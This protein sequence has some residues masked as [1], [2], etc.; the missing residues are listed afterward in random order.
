MVCLC[1]GSCFYSLVAYVVHYY[2]QCLYD[3]DSVCCRRYK[4]H[5]FSHCTLIFVFDGRRCPYKKRNS[6]SAEKRRQALRDKDAATTYTA[7]ERA[8]KQLVTIDNDVLYW[9]KE[10]IKGRNLSGKIKM[11]GAPFETD[12]QLVALEREGIIDGMLTDDGTWVVSG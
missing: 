11:F 12:A 2:M 4:A 5:N 3:G 1:C 8:L 9:V 6:I 7:M 10:W